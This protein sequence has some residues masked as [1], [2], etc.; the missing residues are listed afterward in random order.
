M[1]STIRKARACLTILASL[2]G[3]ALVPP[4]AGGVDAADLSQQRSSS[5][6]LP[7]Y[8]QRPQFLQ[9]LLSR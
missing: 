7:V 3:A 2:A 1:T 4:L 6:R 8:L 9:E 5:S